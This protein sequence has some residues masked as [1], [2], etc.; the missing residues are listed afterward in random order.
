MPSAA[1]LPSRTRLR[2]GAPLAFAALCALLVAGA[3]S[4]AELRLGID[5]NYTYNSNYFSDNQNEDAANSFQLGPSIEIADQE[6]RFRYEVQFDGAY[7]LYLDQDGVDAWESR[8]RARATY[9]LTERTR[10]RVTNRFRDISNLRFGR[11]D[12]EVADTALDPNQDRYFRN[13][14]ELELIHDVTELLELRLRGEH[15]WVDFEQNLDRNDST[16]WQ[17][18]GE[19]RYQVSNTHFVGVGASYTRQDFEEA[20]SRIGSTGDF[21]SGFA[22]WTWIV[23]DAITFTAN[24]GPSWIRSDEDSIA[25]VAQTRLVGGQQGGDVRIAQL[26]N[27]GPV[28][29]GDRFSS[30]CVLAPVSSP[31]PDGTFGGLLGFDVDPTTPRVGDDDQLTFFGGATLTANLPNWNLTVSYQR[32]QSSTTG[33]GLASS[34]DRVFGEVEFAPASSRWSVFAAGSWDRRETLTRSTRIDFVLID[35]ADLTRLAERDASALAITSIRSQDTRRDNFTVI[36][37]TRFRIEDQFAATLDG[38]YRRT[39]LSGPGVNRPDIDTFF[40][41]LTFEYDFVPIQL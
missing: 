7:Q 10:V 30:N 27:C 17:G 21:V 36:A 18:A 20:L 14:V 28:I 2:R 22:T 35:D 16:A 37:G 1:S 19:L 34:L 15:Q 24:G 31:S 40:V 11:Q 26:G 9:D 8:L 32:R 33:D 4:A 12:I 38:R 3:G 23:T 6:G 29:G 5:G 39:E 41:V 25:R 13:E